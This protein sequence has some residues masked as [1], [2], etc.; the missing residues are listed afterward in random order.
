MKNSIVYFLFGLFFSQQITIG[1]IQV[2]DA[3]RDHV[4]IMGYD[5]DTN[6]DLID[7]VIFDFNNDSLHIIHEGKTF[8]IDETTASI[9]DKDG[10]LL[11]YSNGCSIADAQHQIIEGGDTINYSNRWESHCGSLGYRIEQGM[12][13]LPASIE[14]ET[15]YFFYVRYNYINN[16]GLRPDR[17]SAAKVGKNELGKWK[18]IFKDKPLIQD[19]LLVSQHLSTCRHAN[20]RDWWVTTPLRYTNNYYK[21]LIQKDSIIGPFSQNIGLPLGGFDSSSG[22]C[23]FTPDGTKYIDY[24][25]TADLQIFDFDR[26]TGEFSHPIHIPIQDAADT[27]WAAGVAVSPNSRYLY[28][29]SSLYIYQFDLWADDIE[30]SKIT[31][32][33]YDGFE[34]SPGWQTIFY[35]AQLAPDGKIYVTVP[36]GQ[37]AIHVIEYPDRAGL[38]CEVVQHK[39]I[40]PA[41]IGGGL[42]HFPNFRLGAVEGSVCDSLVVGIEELEERELSVQIFPNPA[43]QHITIRN[44]E[45]V[46]V[47]ITS[48]VGKQMYGRQLNKGDTQINTQQWGNGLYIVK[49][50]SENGIISSQKIVITH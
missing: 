24:A 41:Y 38:A 32:A 1:Q 48:I 36:G 43:N 22:G 23:L 45:V 18:I 16:V 5:S 26:C 6:D 40:L 19:T 31:V 8:S 17:L 27:L 2:E 37:E 3:K 28:V 44:T 33:T 7:A 42:P 50:E 4:W 29:S 10:N 13:A 15:F 21:F 9:C 20:G 12:L 14:E 34:T 35:Q 47:Q 11:L 46:K 39:H 49:A 25:I 30:D